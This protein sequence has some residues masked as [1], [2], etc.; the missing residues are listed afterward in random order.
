[1]L[2]RKWI[3]GSVAVAG[4]LFAVAAH[5]KP[6][7]SGFYLGA[8]AGQSKYSEDLGGV[9][10]SLFTAF[11]NVGLTVRSVT[12]EVD[13]TDTNFAVFGGYRFF[14]YLAAEFGYVDLG[15]LSYNADVVLLGTSVPGSVDVTFA[16]KGPLGSALGI[17][18][19][20]DSWDV[21]ARAGIY[22]SD[23]KLKATVSLLNVTDSETESKA[24]VDSMIGLGTAVHLGNHFSLR[25][26]YQRF[27]AVGDE[28]T[29]GE[30]NIDLV[31]AGFLVRF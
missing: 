22:I 3:T 10:G 14:P 7:K 19:I 9:D 31:N 4:L 1:M 16:S 26:E 11:S 17:W 13:D 8:T 25:L 21:Y 20:N 5:A 6:P 2:L 15:E 12:S 24:S 23:T 29:T 30:T 27:G 18:P 28:D